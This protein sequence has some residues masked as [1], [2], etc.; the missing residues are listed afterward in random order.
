MNGL[1]KLAMQTI[2]QNIF[3]DRVVAA[4]EGPGTDHKEYLHIWP[5]D[6][7]MVALELKN[8]NPELAEKIVKSVLALSKI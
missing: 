6:S 8:S 1:L 5:R 7:L 2:E 3:Y 4:P